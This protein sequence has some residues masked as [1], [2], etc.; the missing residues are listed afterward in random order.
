MALQ[1][2]STRAEAQ[3]LSFEDALLTG[4]ARDGG[5]YVPAAW[6]SIT[7]GQVAAFAG[8]PYA[9]VACALLRPYLGSSIGEDDFRRIVEDAYAAFA[10]PAVVP[11]VQ[12]GA[13]DF[14][15]ELFHGPTLAF[16]DV[17]MQLLARLMDHVLA[18][19]GEKVT[20]IG[21][22]SGDTGAAAI[23][24][25]RGREEVDLFILHP[26]GRV[27]EVQ[28]R[29]M[30]TVPDGNVHNIALEGTFDDCQRIVKALF[31]DLALRD[32]LRFSGIN[33]INW[34]RVMAQCVYYVTAA[35]SLGAPHRKIAF[36]VPSGNFGD[37]YAGYMARQMGLAVERL[38][39]ATNVNDILVRTLNTGRYQTQGVVAT[40]SPSMD[41]QVSSNFERLLFDLAGRDGGAVKSMMQSLGA[42]GAFALGQGMQDAARELFA[43]HMCNE[44]ETTA[45]MRDMF[46]KT[47]MV[48]DP[49]TAVGVKA[50]SDARKNGEIDADTALV[51]LA[52]AHP[53][54]FPDAVAAAIGQQ[55]KLPARYSDLYSR[56]E[57]FD[58][59]PNDV[60][61]VAGFIEARAR[62]ATL[63]ER[64]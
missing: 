47:G 7:G 56:K 54:K 29:Q 9:E 27:S 32:R 4:L 61:A 64:I 48:I 6:P 42:T 19:R 58:I 33:S 35:A 44:A 43:G 46:E 45:T 12:T 28:R 13:N 1:Y 31:S 63:Q 11:L 30:T 53:A 2:I 52:T 41:I 26:K 51:T 8:R 5:L 62:A 55:P 17:A 24:A 20:I 37:V 49:H 21:A 18:R 39:V 10:H 15:L 57:R 34:A 50:A 14:I 22:T 3:A 40:Q 25:F 60:A 36:S 23:E 59:L 16:K 38:V